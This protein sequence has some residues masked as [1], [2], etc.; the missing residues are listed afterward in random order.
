M[1]SLFFFLAEEGVNSNLMVGFA[2]LFHIGAILSVILHVLQK[3]REPRSA[4]LWILFVVLFP[5]LGLIAY[6]LFGINTIPNKQWAKMFSD[7]RFSK[8]Q[9]STQRLR[10]EEAQKVIQQASFILNP[11]ETA[12]PALNR[13]LAQLPKDR[14]LLDGNRII[15]LNPAEEA[16][17]RMFAEIARARDHIHLTTYILA[18]DS[19]GKRL[20]DLLRERADAGIHVRVLY[21]AFGSAGPEFRGFFKKFKRVKNLS[22]VPFSQSN[23]F[24]RQFQLNLRNH[25]KILIIDGA[26]AFTGGV[27]FHEVYLPKPGKPAVIDYHFE[28]R[29]PV[30]RELQYTFMRDWFYMTDDPIDPCYPQPERAGEMPVRVSDSSPTQ[31]GVTV[32]LNL[33][34][35][36][37][38]Q[39]RREIRIITPYFVPSE[40]LMLALCQAARRG[41]DIQ[42]L[43]PSD[44][45]HP[46]IRFAS[47]AHYRQLLEAGV[48][49]FER[50]PPFIHTKAM[51]IDQR[52]SIIGSANLDP[53]SLSLNY[54]T[55]LQVESAAFADTLRY[56]MEADFSEALEI[57]L[58]AWKL[59][60]KGQILV[61][62]FF[63]L[64]NPIA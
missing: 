25:R 5:G 42:L 39:A 49:L 12:F 34:V 63:N 45:N 52:L 26:V 48:R 14:P 21:D 44:N 7:I 62:N 23:I 13:L 50:R 64:F 22:L 4:L 29:G 19:V 41:V 53:R 51:V 60:P 15:L 16:L 47:H 9:S 8:H 6:I 36:A 18:D 58:S 54:E 61:E 40:S 57:Q 55:N 37:I 56:A 24:K 10:S 43:T 2:T 27:N 32:A 31:E 38:Q 17:E 3:P 28:I 11:D 20:M 46:T 1:D 30:V 33:F 59:R 35:A